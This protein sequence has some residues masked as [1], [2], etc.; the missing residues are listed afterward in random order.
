MLELISLAEKAE[1]VQP[2][3]VL[4]YSHEY[5]SSVET[6][7]HQITLMET[8]QEANASSGEGQIRLLLKA[9]GTTAEMIYKPFLESVRALY[10][11]TQATPV[12]QAPAF[13]VMVNELVQKMPGSKL[14]DPDSSF[15]RN[16]V[17]H[18]R[19]RFLPAK[20]VVELSDLNHAPKEY[21]ADALKMRIGNW[22]V[23][24][25]LMMQKV[26]QLISERYWAEMIAQAEEILDKPH[27]AG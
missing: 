22:Y 26:R 8:I 11:V 25:V 24:S 15:I 21:T 12:K 7:G 23:L 20:G 4:E 5:M 6:F 27:A 18:G 9:A 1:S 16:A 2:K 3:S 19:H 13:G 10:Y 17:M 14:V